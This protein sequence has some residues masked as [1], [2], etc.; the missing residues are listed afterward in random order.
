[1]KQWA[2][3]QPVFSDGQECANRKGLEPKM[4]VSSMQPSL[5]EVRMQNQ[6]STLP[7]PPSKKKIKHDIYITKS[8]RAF[9]HSIHSFLF[10][11]V[12]PFSFIFS[13]VLGKKV[14]LGTQYAK[15]ALKKDRATKAVGWLT[16]TP[17][18]SEVLQ[19]N[20]SLRG[21]LHVQPSCM[22]SKD[23]PHLWCKKR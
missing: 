1:M 16:F 14:C 17:N 11:F 3:K 21:L 22:F 13:S 4:L 6:I 19:R 2:A 10:F 8:A 9:L 5:D 20:K 18:Y 23:I 7:P 15:K 12:F